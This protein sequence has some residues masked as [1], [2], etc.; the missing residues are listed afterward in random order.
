MIYDKKQRKKDK[1]VYS[2]ACEP[3]SRRTHR[4]SPRAH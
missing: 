3:V 1:K 4:I 2:N